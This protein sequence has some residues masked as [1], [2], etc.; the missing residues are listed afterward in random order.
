LPENAIHLLRSGQPCI[1]I[2]VVFKRS[3]ILK[4]R[5]TIMRDL[6][7]ELS[8]S[9]A[10]FELIRA[11]IDDAKESFEKIL[12]DINKINTEPLNVDR[13]NGPYDLGIALIMIDKMSIA[14]L[15]PKE[16]AERLN[17]HIKSFFARLP[18]GMEFYN[19][20]D[21]YTENFQVFGDCYQNPFNCIAEQL[22][23][24][25]QNK[26]YSLCCENPMTVAL[27]SRML[28]IC[29]GRLKKCQENFNLVEG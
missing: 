27:L 7:P 4:G 3:I 16:Q 17:A 6:L 15:F 2:N 19:L 28:V 18:E 21:E 8:E 26:K 14:N 23:C 29:S 5:I 9:R 13:V 22:L 24:K 10:V 11:P 12:E 1:S 25:W 20:I